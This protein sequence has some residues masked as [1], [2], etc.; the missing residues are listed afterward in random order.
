LATKAG[1]R[2]GNF[3]TNGVKRMV[4]VTAPSAA[5]WM[6]VSMKALPSRNSRSPSGV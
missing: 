6:K 3:T 1:G 5:A 2:T 4:S